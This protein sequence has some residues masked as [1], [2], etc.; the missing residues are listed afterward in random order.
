[1]SVRDLLLPL[2]FNVA[3]SF[4]GIFV[5]RFCLALKSQISDS[6]FP[7][8]AEAPSPFAFVLSLS[9]RAQRGTPPAPLLLSFRCH[10]EVAVATEESLMNL[11]LHRRTPPT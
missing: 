5:F 3:P 1:M 11:C 9:F 4:T 2:G 10:S 8:P 6:R 7:C